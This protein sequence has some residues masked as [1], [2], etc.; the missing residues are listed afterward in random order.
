MARRMP[1]AVREPTGLVAAG[2]GAGWA[3]DSVA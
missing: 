3:A 2:G 1:R